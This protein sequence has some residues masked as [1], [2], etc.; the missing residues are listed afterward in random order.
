MT[1]AVLLTA[2]FR[3]LKPGDVVI[4][5]RDVQQRDPTAAATTKIYRTKLST[6]LKLKEAALA[7]IGAGAWGGCGDKGQLEMEINNRF[8][9]KAK[10]ADSVV[11]QWVS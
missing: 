10:L 11:I 3:T 1:N 5:L 4:L 7:A 6:T 2:W 9:V 8:G